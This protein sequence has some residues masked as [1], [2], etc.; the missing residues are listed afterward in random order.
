MWERSPSA[1]G[2]REKKDEEDGGVEEFQLR[3]GREGVEEQV[4]MDQ[5]ALCWLSPSVRVIRAAQA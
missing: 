4:K 5:M 1:G 2:S 3:C